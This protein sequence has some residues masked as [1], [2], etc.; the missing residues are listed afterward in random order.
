MSKRYGC[1]FETVYKAVK[2]ENLE[3]LHWDPDVAYSRGYWVDISK[4]VNAEQQTREGDQPISTKIEAATTINGLNTEDVMA[5]VREYGNGG[6][7]VEEADLLKLLKHEASPAIA[8]QLHNDMTN[9]PLLVSPN[10]KGPK[11]LKFLGLLIRLIANSF[12]EFGDDP[13]DLNNWRPRERFHRIRCAE[14]DV[15][16]KATNKI[17]LGKYPISYHSYEVFVNK[18]KEDCGFC[19]IKEQSSDWESHGRYEAEVKRLERSWVAINKVLSP[20]RDFNKTLQLMHGDEVCF[21]PH[22]R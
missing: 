20:L 13:D 9:L 12:F 19:K 8:R 16:V 7:P 3:L 14:N 2:E 5:M 21:V 1:F 22:Q 17:I 18:Y 6:D 15:F 10:A 4:S 11:R